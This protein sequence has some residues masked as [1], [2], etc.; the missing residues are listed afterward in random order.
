MANNDIKNF[1]PSK[2][3]SGTFD[4]QLI[5][6]GP[7]KIAYLSCK[8][9]GKWMNLG[10]F[11]KLTRYKPYEQRNAVKEVEKAIYQNVVEHD[12]VPTSGIKILPSMIC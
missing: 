7:I 10:K 3:V 1:I 6:H 11:E 12:N 4:R 8:F 9:H 2:F 5:E